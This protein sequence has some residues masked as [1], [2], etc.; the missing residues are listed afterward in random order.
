MLTPH[1]AC[2]PI[3][4]GV[5]ARNISLSSLR[6]T[7]TNTLGRSILL[8]PMPTIFFLVS[9]LL[10]VFS[11]NLLLLTNPAFDLGNIEE[12][13]TASASKSSLSKILPR[14]ATPF[15]PAEDNNYSDEDS[16]EVSFITTI[17]YLP[18]NDTHSKTLT[19]GP[20]FPA[21]NENSLPEDDNDLFPGNNDEDLLDTDSPCNA[22][23]SPTSPLSDANLL[24]P[25]ALLP[26]SNSRSKSEG[27]VTFC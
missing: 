1:C 5:S 3:D 20:S 7:R 10:E 6:E 2:D 8:Q 14:P 26:I 23:P 25:E 17:T 21:D 18:L 11:E 22:A 19:T 15:R 12:D 9:H 4:P 24:S 27:F 13:N 16:D